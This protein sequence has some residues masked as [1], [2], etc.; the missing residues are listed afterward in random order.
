MNEIPESIMLNEYIQ[1]EYLGES[2]ISLKNDVRS[3]IPAAVFGVQ[4]AEKYHLAAMLDMPVIYISRDGLSARNAATELR[5][6]TGKKGVYLPAKDDVLL[7]NKAFNKENYYERIT[8]LYR[9][10][11]GVDFVTCT[12]ESL[13]QLMPEKID[14]VELKK[15]GESELS[16][17]CERLVKM[18]YVRVEQV[19]A[20]GRFSVRGDIVH[21]YPVNYDA[22]V[23]IDFFGDEIEKIVYYDS[24]GEVGGETASLVVLPT[25]DFTVD[26]AEK[27]IIKEALKNAVRSFGTQIYANRARDVA[28]EISLLL[29]TT[30]TDPALSFVLPLLS[31]MK[32]SVRKFMGENAVVVYDECK[33]LTDSLNGT[34]KEFSDRRLALAAKGESFNFSAGQYKTWEQLREELDLPRKVAL[35]SLTSQIPFFNP[36][37]TYRFN[38][39]PVPRYALRPDDFFDDVKA[40]KI[41]GY[42]VLVC[43]GN[44]ERAARL[45]GYLEDRK[46]FSDLGDNFPSDFSGVKITSYYLAN[47]FIYHDAKVAVI[48]T[49]DLYS[50]KDR[51]KKIKRKRGDVYYAPEVGDY[52]VHERHGIGIVRGIERITTTDSTK[53]YVAIEYRGGD[54]LY[55]G[56]DRMDCL[57]KYMGGEEKPSLSRLGG[58]EFEKVKE[59]VKA[60]IAKLTINLKKLY[61]D[62]KDAKGFNFLP[63]DA[64]MREFEEAFPFEET[65]DQLQSIEEIKRDME[66]SRVMDRLLCGDVG[67]G[68]TEVA[69]RAAFKAVESGK[70]VAF[71]A[72]TTILVEQHYMTALNRFKDFPVRIAVL[73]RFRTPSEQTK[74]LFELEDGKVDLI[75]GTHRLFSKDVKFKDLGL[76]ILDEEQRFGVEHKEKLKLLKENV[77]T[78]TLSAT[79]IP[80]TL[81]MSLTGIRDIS[82]INTPPTERIPVQI[83]VTEETDALIVDALSKELSRGGQAFVLYNSVDSISAFATRV[84]ELMPD[85]RIIIGHGRMPERQLEE[86]VMSFYRGEYDVLIATTIIENGID[87]PNA[88]TLIVIDADKLGL[89]TL[90]QLKGRVGRSD[91][92]ARAY[93]TYKENKVISDV[94]YKR[95][96][97]LTEFSEFGSGFKIAM[98][99]LEIRGAGNVLGK[100]Q[101]G[102]MEKIGYEL[103]TKLLK[104][105]L[106]EVTKNFETELEIGVTAFIPENYVRS[107]AM[108]MDA[109][110][111]IAEISNANDEAR[112]CDSLKANYGDMPAETINL[113][114]IARLKA[115]CAGFEIIKAVLNKKVAKLIF[116]NLDSLSIGGIVDTL[117]GGKTSAKLTFG[118]NPEIHFETAGKA[119][120]AVLDE[121]TEFLLNSKALSD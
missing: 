70:Q 94:A 36:L 81:H 21:I 72:P 105:Q 67:Y 52:C 109:Y 26:P 90:Y 112:V 60:S 57:T 108:R 39:T 106:G 20:K 58:Q 59:R 89:S 71:I 78:L 87:L 19:D 49:N 51:E 77:D 107:E 82:I 29:E 35:Q 118:E 92:M 37:K 68:K 104:E 88:N 76:L 115:L 5:A 33:L 50:R 121:M 110:K 61:R 120:E 6:L 13:L 7:Y 38:C 84:R 10:S 116:K 30:E 117:N 17:L 111:Q 24:A 42:K 55:V 101:H 93:F 53:D 114:K 95:L 34:L 91:R 45:H 56:V 103:Y 3:G 64:M 12:F 40:W 16:E 54:M 66:S 8:A 99:D 2:F 62:R 43:C 47:G 113:I 63:D 85:A 83:F 18:G 98:R 97:A 27:T 74:T 28:Q 1:A 102:H 46:I 96:S 15:G 69:L 22:P 11:K 4:S 86:N 14:G 73:D 31:C 65:E 100:E 79:P 32:G 9:L 75:F 41:T 25:V 48:G 80:R 44:G 119:S 23:R